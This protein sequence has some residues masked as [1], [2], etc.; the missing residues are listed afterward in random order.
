MGG[1]GTFGV[2]EKIMSLRKDETNRTFT[3]VAIDNESIRLTF[4]LLL[5]LTDNSK[6]NA[7]QLD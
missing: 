7:F 6:R 4:R 5:I 3:E 2:V 1:Q